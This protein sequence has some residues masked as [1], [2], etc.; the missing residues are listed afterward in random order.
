M[1]KRRSFT[2]DFKLSVL[3]ELQTK[4]WGEV[5]R[6]HSL[7]PSVIHQ[8]RKDF[9]VNP[10]KAFSGNGNTWREE[11]INAKYERLIGQLYAENAFLKKTLERLQMLRK[12]EK[13]ARCLT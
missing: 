6:E 3:Q 7:N 11:A 5:C 8:W 10:K 13:R 2:R 12:E 4:K 9:A 1:K